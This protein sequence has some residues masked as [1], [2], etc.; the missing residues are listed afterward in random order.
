MNFDAYKYFYFNPTVRNTVR[1]WVHF[2]AGS[3]S[4]IAL[5]SWERHLA[6]IFKHFEPFSYATIVQK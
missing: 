1:S 4:H 6:A 2:V 3:H 5:T